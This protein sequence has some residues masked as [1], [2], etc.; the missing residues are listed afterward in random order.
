[1][2]Q[3]ADFWKLH[4]LAL[5]GEC[6]APGVWGVL[7]EREVCSGAVVRAEVATQDVPEV[8]LAESR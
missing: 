2:V 3:T 8:V 6:D 7:V 4:D 1:M 5:R